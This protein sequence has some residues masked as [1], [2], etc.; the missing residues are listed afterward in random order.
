MS[1]KIKNKIVEESE[2]LLDKNN[3]FIYHSSNFKKF[4]QESFNC[5]YEL[6]KSP[7]TKHHAHLICGINNISIQNAYPL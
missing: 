3:H 5:E 2:K 1:Q 7:K 6:F 4:I